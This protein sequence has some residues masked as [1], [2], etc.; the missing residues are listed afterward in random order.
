MIVSTGMSEVSEIDETYQFL[1]DQ[2]VKLILM[3]CTSAY[4][5]IYSELHLG[6]IKVMTERYGKAIIGHSDHTNDIYSSL[7]AI[8]LGARVIEKHVTID[9]NLP[10]PDASV[11]LTFE[12]L[13]ELVFA[14][15]EISSAL[16]AKKYIHSNEREIIEWARRSIVSTKKISKGQKIGEGD[17]W[18][19]RPGTG[20]PTK[21]YWDLIGLV[22]AN[23]IN[24]NVLLKPS[25]L[26]GFAE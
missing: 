23:D 24:E 7:V 15:K 6:F 18:G 22:A 17:I 11:S 12:K 20:I 3:N 19:K 16:S 9:N 5:P 10:G 21:R 14:S 1:V 13:K 26:V 2:D 8:G 4:P 25:D